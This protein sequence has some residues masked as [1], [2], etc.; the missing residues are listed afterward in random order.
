MKIVINNCY[1]GFRLSDEAC[2][3]LGIKGLARYGMRRDD[4]KLVACVEKL[5]P[6]ASG[7]ASRLEIVEIPDNV[8]WYISDDETG[9]EIV[10]EKHRYWTGSRDGNWPSGD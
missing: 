2:K 8:D 3:E 5:G 1:G 4:P 10:R 7:E 6:K 9:I